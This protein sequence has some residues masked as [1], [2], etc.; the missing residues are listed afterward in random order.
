MNW[1]SDNNTLVIGNVN[2]DAKKIDKEEKYWNVSIKTVDG[3]IHD[4]QMLESVFNDIHKDKFIYLWDGVTTS[5][6]SVI[7]M[8]H[9][10][11]I[12][13]IREW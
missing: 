1:L 5:D 2:K 12:T 3:E 11:K 8:Q 10:I 7:N 13:K 4:T 9:V 6:K